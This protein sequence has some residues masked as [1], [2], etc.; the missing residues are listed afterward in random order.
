MRLSL[1][2][3]ETTAMTE[4]PGQGKTSKAF[5]IAVWVFPII[6]LLAG[7]IAWITKNNLSESDQHSAKGLTLVFIAW[8]GVSLSAS[9]CF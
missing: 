3:R 1:E 5:R 9:C 6:L 2:G 7:W 4:T 8:L